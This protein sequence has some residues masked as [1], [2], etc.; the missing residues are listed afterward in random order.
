MMLFRKRLL[1]V[2]LTVFGAV[3]LQ[4]QEPGLRDDQGRTELMNYVIW[5][6]VDIAVIKTDISRLWDVCYEYVRIWTGQVNDGKRQ[7]EKVVMR[8]A[9]C[10][11]S[12]ILAL[13]NREQDLAQCIEQTV[14]GIEAMVVTESELNAHDNDG[15]TVLNHC[16]TYEIYEALRAHGVPFQYV[17]YAYFNPQTI[18][19]ASLGLVVLAVYLYQNGY[20]PSANSGLQ[21]TD[22]QNIASSLVD[23]MVVPAIEEAIQDMTAQDAFDII[24]SMGLSF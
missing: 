17:V 8:R 14:V 15:K 5:Q 21:S 23:A 7:Y 4:A 2:L 12:D 22:N 3:A 1:S 20:L 13:Q 16:Q 18:A 6:E 19:V 11:D 10:M 9:S 24:E